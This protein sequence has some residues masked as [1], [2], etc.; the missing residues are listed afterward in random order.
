[1]D[2][3]SDERPERTTDVHERVVD[4]V[5]DGADILFGGASG[6]TD[7]AGLDEGDADCG[8]H[9]D[10]SNKHDQRNCLADRGEPRG[11]ER[12][13]EEIGSCQNKISEGKGTTKTQAIGD[14]AAE[15]GEKPDQAAEEAGEIRSTLRRKRERLMKIASERGESGIVGKTFKEFRN[16]GDPEGTLEAGSY[17]MKTL[18]ETHFSP[19][20][21]C[22]DCT[23][24]RQGS[25]GVGDKYRGWSES[26]NV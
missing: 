19:G 24:G 3:G 7:D 21:K 2:P 23:G 18:A 15:D 4:G 25:K 26:P 13:E 8:K 17:L 1:V 20:G 11:T 12:A 6:G 22:S 16:V 10:H 14:G 9:Q 5:T